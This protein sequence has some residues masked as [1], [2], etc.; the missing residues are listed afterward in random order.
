MNVNDVLTLVNVEGTGTG[1][2]DTGKGGITSG[3]DLNLFSLL[4]KNMTGIQ[5]QAAGQKSEE[6]AD[7][8]TMSQEEN[9]LADGI[10]GQNFYLQILQ[11]VF[12]AGKEANS[13]LEGG[14]NSQSISLSELT[15][16][17]MPGTNAEN[18]IAKI[19][20][21]GSGKQDLGAFEGKLLGQ[22]GEGTLQQVDLFSLQQADLSTSIQDVNQVNRSSQSGKEM[23]VRD[24]FSAQNE[25]GL[26]G[27]INPVSGES[28]S[29]DPKEL[30]KY[31]K[32]FEQLQELSGKIELVSNRTG[33]GTV[34]KTANSEKPE[35]VKDAKQYADP[36][37]TDQTTSVQ[38]KI[39]PLSAL[40][41][42]GQKPF[43]SGQDDLGQ[44]APSQ[45]NSAVQ[46][47]QPSV[48]NP[49]GIAASGNMPDP[50]FKVP[51]EP[52]R[53]WEQVLDTLQKQE[54]K[55]NEVKELSIRLQPAE[56]GKVDVSL[57][58]ENGQLHLVMNA[59]EQA[60]GTILQNHMQELKNGL[61]Q[62]G[63]SCGNFEMNYRQN[64]KSGSEREF[65]RN[66]NR[67]K[68]H[69]QEEEIPALSSAGSYLSVNGSGGKIN[70]SA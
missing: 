12:P 67:Y 48:N 21:S 9:I 25:T 44:D 18:P 64:E 62:M 63:V 17:L 36:V 65:S 68:A 34:V 11:N 61:T 5:T 26:E 39:N 55:A 27:I 20:E 19:M 47:L 38:G 15:G 14:K 30:D 69:F 45:K 13:G 42:N 66:S 1:N 59:S 53:V 32:T 29:L 51:A 22:P 54:I 40:A 46:S 35:M 37:E 31:I 3:T 41:N 8:E 70:V 23:N 50:K 43:S 4:F 10:L 56:L 52:G 49:D 28:K 60:T 57:R 24:Y 58:M 7:D 6:Q 2:P 16:V 33:S